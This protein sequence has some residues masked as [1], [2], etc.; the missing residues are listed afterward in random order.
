MDA[1][2]TLRPLVPQES[3][4]AVSNNPEMLLITDTYSNIQRLKAVIQQIEDAMEKPSDC[5]PKK[6]K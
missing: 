3:H 5:G 6:Q 1:L 2:S 4:L